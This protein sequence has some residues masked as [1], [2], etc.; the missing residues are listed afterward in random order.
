VVSMLMVLPRIQSISQL[1]DH[2]LKD[3]SADLMVIPFWQITA[4]VHSIVLSLLCVHQ[5]PQVNAVLTFLMIHHKSIWPIIQFVRLHK[6]AVDIKP[7]RVQRREI[8]SRRLI[9]SIHN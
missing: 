6:W 7:V 2:L 1:T 9:V 5:K 4:Q 8:D 3:A